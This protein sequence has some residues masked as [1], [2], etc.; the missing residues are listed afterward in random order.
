MA[1][2]LGLDA[3]GEEILMQQRRM[4]CHRRLDIDDVRQLFVLDFDQLDRFGR[5]RRRKGRHPAATA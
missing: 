1:F 4:L 2:R 3:L 5:D